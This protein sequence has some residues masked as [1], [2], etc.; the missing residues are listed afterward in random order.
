MDAIKEDRW[1]ITKAL[2]DEFPDIRCRVKEY[3]RKIE[4]KP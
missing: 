3:L 2:L 4:K 1:L